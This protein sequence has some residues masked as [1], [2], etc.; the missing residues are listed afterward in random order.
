[1]TIKE[2]DIMLQYLKVLTLKKVV[3]YEE[4]PYVATYYKNNR[5]RESG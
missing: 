5:K 2:A 1:M 4:S 3:V